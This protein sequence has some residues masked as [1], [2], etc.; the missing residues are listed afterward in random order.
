MPGHSSGHQ[1]TSRGLVSSA[2][3]LRS[4]LG[5]IPTSGTSNCSTEVSQF[6]VQL[7]TDGCL[8]TLMTLYPLPAQWRSATLACLQRSPFSEAWFPSTD[9]PSEQQTSNIWV[10]VIN[11]SS[12]IPHLNSRCVNS[13]QLLVK[14]FVQRFTSFFPQHCKWNCLC[15]IRTQLLVCVLS[16]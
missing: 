14:S 8:N 1:P 4:H 10:S 12:S 5:W 7:W 9:A 15:F 13:D 11:Q 3:Y 2:S 6:L 16:A